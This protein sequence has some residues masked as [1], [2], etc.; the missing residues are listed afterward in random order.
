M[1]FVSDGFSL[2]ASSLEIKLRS[3]YCYLILSFRLFENV[4]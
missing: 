4:V 3:T 1:E 2:A